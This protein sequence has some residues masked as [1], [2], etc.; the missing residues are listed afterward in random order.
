MLSACVAEWGLSL[1]VCG[2]SQRKSLIHTSIHLGYFIYGHPEC[3][4]GYFQFKQKPGILPLRAE[5][6]C[7]AHVHLHRCIC[8][9][10]LKVTAAAGGLLKAAFF[11]PHSNLGVLRSDTT[12]PLSRFVCFEYSNQHDVP[13]PS[14]LSSHITARCE[15]GNNNCATFT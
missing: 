13:F 7:K 11:L 14:R 1:T 8:I 10:A 2:W 6:I 12:A 9:T 5:L 15:K 4:L 3:L